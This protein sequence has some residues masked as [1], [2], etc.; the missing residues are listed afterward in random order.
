MIGNDDFITTEFLAI[1]QWAKNNDVD[2][3]VGSLSANYRWGNTGAKDTFFTKI[4]GSTLTINI[5]NCKIQRVNLE[6]S[7]DQLMGGGCP[8]YL[9][10][11]LPKLNHRVVKRF[12]FEII[13]PYGNVLYSI[14]I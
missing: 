13:N 6:N 3:V 12:Y 4:S 11:L 9:D 10:L 14:L 7:L 1:T 2:A 8:N 5:F